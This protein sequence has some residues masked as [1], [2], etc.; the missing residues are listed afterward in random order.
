M[1]VNKDIHVSFKTIHKACVCVLY[2][3]IAGLNSFGHD[4]GHV[5]SLL[6]RTIRVSVFRN[7]ELAVLIVCNMCADNCNDRNSSL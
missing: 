2:I 7:V 4:R 5:Q 1:F 6:Q 3:H